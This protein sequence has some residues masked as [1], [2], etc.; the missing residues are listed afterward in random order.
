MLALKAFQGA[1]WLVFSRFIGRAIDFFTLL[2]LARM[3]SPSDFGIAALATSLVVIVDTVL[4]V[5][6]TQALVRLPA[7]DKR[8]LDTGFTLNVVRCGVMAVLILCA[9]LPFSLL[10]HEPLLPPLVCVLAL[11]PISRAFASPAMVV[12]ARE[13]NFK[14]T[15]ILEVVGKLVASVV[16][17]VIVLKGGSYWA[18]VANY[19][20][21]SVGSSI[22]SYV[23]APYRPAIS[24]VRFSD[25]AGFMGW[26]SSAQLI[27]ALNWQ[28][29]R[30]MIGVFSDRAGLGRYA[31]AND[32][33]VIPTQS[34][35]GP[36]LQPVMAA[37][38]QIN[39]DPIRVRGA[40]LKAARFAMI[41]SIPVCV[42]ISVTADLATSILLGSKWQEAAPIL[43]I[44]AVA[45]VPTPYFQ[46][47]YSVSVAIDRPIVVFRLNAIDFC[48]RLVL[49]PIG[50]YANSIL[51][52]SYARLVLSFIMFG[53]YLKT[54]EALLGLPV[55][56]QLRNLWKIA[57]AGMVM[58]SWVWILR[59]ELADL[60]LSN[61]VELISVASSGAAAYGVALA[62]LGIRLKAGAG[63]LELVDRR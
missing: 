38:S 45:V 24:L 3:L 22:V 60:S 29:D 42:G 47:L 55:G 17:T 12:Y 28:F 19:V 25:F 39:S 8:H 40:F 16:A 37:F 9:A 57:L 27:S 32:I 23:L 20:I 5:P 18:I 21:V 41:I 50:F 34:I 36:A 43:S 54:A 11:G 7:I 26:F 31:V 6:V 62:L 56:D 35:I 4:E 48:F 44:L 51:G 13:M 2:I 33:S 61:T 1:G 46:T 53:F 58:W 49:L 14:Q 52:V 10:N 15:F 30:F 63:R 59:H